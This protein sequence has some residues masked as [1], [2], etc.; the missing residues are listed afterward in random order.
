MAKSTVH[1]V[2]GVVL[3]GGL[4][5]RM[6]RDKVEVQVGGRSLLA[7]T[8]ERLAPQCASL[9]ISRHA[10]TADLSAL[11]YPIVEDAIPGHA[12]PLAGVLAGL[13]WSIARDPTV[14]HVVTT[15]VDTPFL[16]RDFVGRLGAALDVTSAPIACAAS[17]GRIHPVAALWPVAIRSALRDA[18]MVERTRRVFAVLERF[19]YAVVEWSPEPADPFLNVNTP[20]DLTRAEEAAVL[21]DGDAASKFQ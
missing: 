18:V 13:D 15:A 19:G 11:G 6:G 7:R 5:R 20:E 21:L 12:G 2:Q 1:R 16:P 17:G 9:A 4:S 3:A 14:S 8:C 10:E